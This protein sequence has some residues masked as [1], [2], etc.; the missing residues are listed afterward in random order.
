MLARLSEGLR[1]LSHNGAQ[2]FARAVQCSQSTQREQAQ[3]AGCQ[4]RDLKHA[5]QGGC[6]RHAACATQRRVAACAQK[7]TGR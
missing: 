6:W 1:L 4:A 3:D 2:A 5:D 7:K